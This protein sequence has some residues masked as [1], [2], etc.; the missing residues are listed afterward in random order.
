MRIG[1]LLL[2]ITGGAALATVSVP[3]MWARAADDDLVQQIESAKTPADHE[4]LA[5]RYEQMA[6]DARKQAER[7]RKMAAGYAA[8]PAIAG[9]GTRVPLPQHCTNLVKHYEAEAAE[10]DALAAAERELAKAAA[11]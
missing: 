7:H 10:Y 5:A 3:T 1:R 4:A 9:K 8:G 11:K 2:G 6:A